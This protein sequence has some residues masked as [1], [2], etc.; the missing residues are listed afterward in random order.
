MSTAK[1][2]LGLSNPTKI[3]IDDF[4][5]NKPGRKLIEINDE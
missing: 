3:P 5:G 4:F 2:K 1:V